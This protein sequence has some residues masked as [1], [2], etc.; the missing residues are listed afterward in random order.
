M[1]NLNDL[2]RIKEAMITPALMET[3]GLIK[4]KDKLIKIL[5][6]GELKNPVTIQAHA[7]SKGACA[8]I[9]RKGGKIE[10]INV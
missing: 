5:G 1:V 8:E 10:L 4:N 3:E 2:N 7:F 9:K 6:D